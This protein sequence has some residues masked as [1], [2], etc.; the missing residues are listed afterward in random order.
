MYYCMKYGVESH[1][2]NSGISDEPY[3]YALKLLGKVN[4]VLSVE[5]DSKAMSDYKSWICQQLKIFENM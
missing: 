4:Y 5:P 2:V 1:V 3:R